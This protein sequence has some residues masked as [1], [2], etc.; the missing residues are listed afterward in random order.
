MF[1]VG[2]KVVCVRVPEKAI[3][4]LLRNAKLPMVGG[5]Y[6]IRDIVQF[7]NCLL[8]FRELDNAHLANA[9]Y[10]G[11]RIIDGEPGFRA[12]CFRPLV[13]RKTDIS[14]FR[15]ILKDADKRIEGDA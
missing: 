15:R 10:Q 9:E 5:V 12:D 8:L 13:E 7:K 2:Q 11:G 6:T 4:F 14:I 3:C 1:R